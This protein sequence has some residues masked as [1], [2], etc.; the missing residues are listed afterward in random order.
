MN[1]IKVFT[2]LV[3]FCAIE[4]LVDSKP[5]DDVATIEPILRQPCTA[6][7]IYQ[8]VK[9][10]YYAH[11]LLTNIEYMHGFTKVA[12]HVRSISE[13]QWI[14]CEV[15]QYNK[16]FFGPSPLDENR[17]ECFVAHKPCDSDKY[18]DQ[19]ITINQSHYSNGT[20]K[21]LCYKKSNILYIK[22]NGYHKNRKEI[23][24]AH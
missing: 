13:A 5:L 11:K 21:C 2:I 19:G 10:R 23:C 3:I 6:V 4:F 9:G 7:K 8:L 12:K 22:R 15:P 24:N 16:V 18:L 17:D 1:T 14:T 20:D